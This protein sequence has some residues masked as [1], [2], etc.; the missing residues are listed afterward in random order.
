MTLATANQA[1][2]NGERKII[3]SMGVSTER[4]TSY[5]PNVIYFT[6]SQETFH[7]DSTTSS[8]WGAGEAFYL[9]VAVKDTGIGISQ[10]GQQK[11]F[12]RFRLVFYIDC[13]P[14]C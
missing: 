12:E 13:C 1:M 7:V 6:D 9:M 11:L 10:E 14:V 3:V 4:P 5:P 2:Q 8:E